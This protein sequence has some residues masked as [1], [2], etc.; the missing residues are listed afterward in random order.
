MLK[1]REA[2]PT[3]VSGIFSLIK[4]IA[5]YEKLT[6]L[7]TGSEELLAKYLFD[8]QSKTA[9]VL[10]AEWESHLI[11]YALYFFNFSSFLTRP[12]LYL[13]DLYVKPEMRGK[14]VGKALFE[15]LK[16]IARKKDCGRIEWSVLNWNTPSIEFYKNSLGAAPMDEWTVYRL[17]EF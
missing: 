11:G 12:G 1:I 8:A 10:L 15:I 6:H 4:E 9:S 5:E 17:T 13:E 7:V 16:D 14:G 2:L 3:D